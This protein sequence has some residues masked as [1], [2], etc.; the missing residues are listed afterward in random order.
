M[1]LYISQ[2]ISDFDAMCK[3]ISE[4]RVHMQHINEVVTVDLVQVTVGQ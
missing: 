2:V 4:F 1:S 3:L